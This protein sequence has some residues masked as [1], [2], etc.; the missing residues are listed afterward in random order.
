MGTS[1]FLPVATIGVLTVTLFCGWYF[2]SP[3]LAISQLSDWRTAPENLVELYDREKV[4]LA[5]EQQ[6]LPQ[7][8]AYPPLSRKM[9]SWTR[10]PTQ[11]QFELLL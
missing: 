2:L 1:R 10:C 9:S 5:F 6:M 3:R 7:V 11:G 4:R 8:E